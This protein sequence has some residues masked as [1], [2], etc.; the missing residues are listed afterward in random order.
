MGKA[1]I[2][3]R[4]AVLVLWVWGAFLCGG[5]PGWSQ[6]PAP[7]TATAGVPKQEFP[8]HISAAQLEAD[9]NQRLL[10]FKGQV[11]ADYGDAIL[12]TD[13]LLVFF[14]P[15]AKGRPPARPAAPSQAGSPLGDLG[16][17]EIDRI[18]A[19]GNV[20]FVQGDRVATGTNAVYYKDKDEIVL[21]GQPQVWRGENHLKGSKITFNLASQK[22]E[23]ESSP[24]QRVEAHLYP[25]GQEGKIPSSLFSPGG[26]KAAPKTG[27]SH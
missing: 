9:Q 24:E 8:L 20:R 5:S 17:D 4:S 1:K 7:A 16:G 2:L 23:V 22:V 10:V 21:T 19:L 12:Y 3:W 15:A 27:R 6:T 25:S 11:K 18:E 14:K 13:Q 26:R